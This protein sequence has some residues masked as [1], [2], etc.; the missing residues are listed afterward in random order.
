MI[1]WDRVNTAVEW[2]EKAVLSGGIL[3]IAAATI[4][5]V[6]S[7]TLVQRS[8]AWTEELSGFALIAVTFV[9]LSHGAG[10]GRHI[11]MS[12]FYDALSDSARR[13]LRI[14]ICYLTAALLFYLGYFALDYAETVRAL[15]TVSPVLRVPL[16]LVYLWAPLGF[17]M[18]GL[19]Y[20]ATARKNQASSGPVYLSYSQTD[21]AV[22]PPEG[23]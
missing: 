2:V 20:L 14:A 12:A 10:Q 4:A 16:W 23:I 13:K 3:V 5:N 17:G 9:G 11:R 1:V 21:S 22:P 15:G 6:L 18:A 8:L 19:Q 7:R